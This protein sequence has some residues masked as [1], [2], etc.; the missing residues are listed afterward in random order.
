M[1]NMTKE[2]HISTYEHLFRIKKMNAIELFALRTQFDFKNFNTALDT[3]NLI[4][5]KLEVKCDDDWLPVKEKNIYFP[6][7]IED[8]IDAIDELSAEFMKRFRQVF[9]KS[10]VS[11][12]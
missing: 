11:S 3:F 6:V 7:G 5:E 10:N 12:K 2:F 1:E 8:N 4:L 9:Q